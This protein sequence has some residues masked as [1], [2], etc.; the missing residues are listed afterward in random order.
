M[1]MNA[2]QATL[3]TMAVLC[4]CVLLGSG[5]ATG[6]LGDRCRDGADI[7]T[8]TVGLGDGVRARVGPL[9]VPGIRNSDMMG[10]RGGEFF[11]NGGD[12]FLNS[13]R[14]APLAIPSSPEWVQ[15]QKDI[16]A[17]NPSVEKE[18]KKKP[19]KEG[20]WRSWWRK[21]LCGSEVFIQHRDR[22]SSKRGKDVFGYSPLPF[23]VLHKSPAAYTQ[24][25][26]SGGVLVSFRLG[27]NPGEIVDF[28]LGWFGADIY[29]DDL[30]RRAS[31]QD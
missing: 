28:V 2:S 20:W 10:L 12:L 19:K 30:S 6:Y 9:H 21:D 31:R 18:P 8:A 4:L 11:A 3:R 7:L 26:V 17:A 27:F 14:Y 25:E 16:D 1:S 24:I 15:V 5:C 29:G 22:S 13:E 23:I